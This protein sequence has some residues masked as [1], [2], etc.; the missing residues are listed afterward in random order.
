MSAETLRHRL[1]LII[2]LAEPAILARGKQGRE[3]VVSCEID[4][5]SEAPTITAT[6]Q[7]SELYDV[8]I[9]QSSKTTKCSCPYYRQHQEICKHLVSVALFGLSQVKVPRFSDGHFTATA[10]E[11]V[12]KERSILALLGQLERVVLRKIPA[13]STKQDQETLVYALKTQGRVSHSWSLIPS[14]VEFIDNAWQLRQRL[15][16]ATLRTSR[17]VSLDWLDKALMDLVPPTFKTFTENPET[18]RSL[19]M[20][21][22]LLR[23]TKRFRNAE[24]WE[25][26]QVQDGVWSPKLRMVAEPDG[27]ALLRPF[28]QQGE[29]QVDLPNHLCIFG[30]N[31]KAML[32]ENCIYLLNTSLWGEAQLPLLAAHHRLTAQELAQVVPSLSK[33][34]DLV[35]I[36]AELLP[37][38]VQGFPQPWLVVEYSK[39][40]MDLSVRMRYAYLPAENLYAIEPAGGSIPAMSSDGRAVV[41]ARDP[42]AEESWLE[43]LLDLMRN[44]TWKALIVRDRLQIEFRQIPTFI[45]RVLEPLQQNQQWKFHGLQGLKPFQK[46][47]GRVNIRISSGVDWF[48][49]EGDVQFGE[50]SVPLLSLLGMGAED[51]EI[52][53]ADGSLGI[54]PRTLVRLLHIIQGLQGNGSKASQGKLRIAAIHQAVL[55]PL[56]ESDQFHEEQREKLRALLDAKAYRPIAV[57]PVPRMLKATLRP[58]QEEGLQWLRQMCAWGTGGILA[59]DMGLGKTVQVISVLCDFYED[60]KESRCSLIVMPTSLLFNWKKELERFAPHLQ[61]RTYHGLDRTSIDVTSLPK[62]EIML[63]S[64]AILR[65]EIELWNQIDFGYAILDESQAIKNPTSQ[66]AVCARGLRASHRL[67]MT[68]TPIENNLLDLWSQFAFVNPGLLGSQEFFKRE[69]IANIG[70]GEGRSTALDLLS[71]LSAPFYLRRTKEKVLTELPPLEERVL[72]VDMGATQRAFY[73]KTREQYRKKILGQ[74]K[75]QGIQK[76][77]IH[78]IEGMLRLRQICCDPRLYVPTSRAG[79]AK[80]DLLM[81]KLEED[82]IE[83]HKCLV[84]SQF[85]TLLEYCGK[86]LDKVKI[87]YAYLDGSTRNREAAI[88]EFT[89]NSD[90]RVFLISLKAGGTGL[91]LTCAD[92]VFHLDPWWNPAVEAQATGR[93]HRMGQK[94]AVQSIKLV[95]SNSIE[96]KILQLQESKRRLAS[97]V[98]QS[99]QGFLKT[100]D[101][102]LVNEL[103]S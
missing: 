53:L 86:A 79:S 98:L 99:D 8:L 58:Y 10:M 71:R 32:A 20:T 16:F 95:A 66:A 103:F 44:E 28:L 69:F 47:P 88:E 9:T 27:S 4:A 11:P 30:E 14:L 97:A 82:V 12:E 35:E 39:K 59:D 100:L 52:V 6:I 70:E 50:H 25:I 60:P 85:T 3:T 102:D 22:S 94:N 63:T 78:I 1:L 23:G 56:I 57:R 18:P 15:N 43:Q 42:S 90:K 36:P 87:P 51:D 34:Q 55:R 45:Q 48:D 101:A 64:Y 61:V 80:L 84:F 21:L 26:L 54:L 67:A 92:Y 75:E 72:Y 91:N 33:L 81:E 19:V 24:T 74:I 13:G 5:E 38:V 2:N 17:M 62:R 93:A 83:N 40:R 89:T 96:D 31:D 68:G 73:E 37:Q 46:H 76:S 41:V 7:G 49:L 65:N 29:Q 77:Q